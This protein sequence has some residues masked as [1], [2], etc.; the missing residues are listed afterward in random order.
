MP[1]AA[2]DID[3]YLLTRSDFDL[4]LFVCQTLQES[5]YEISHGGT[6][7]DPFKKVPRQFDVRAHRGVRH[8]K[9]FEI[10]LALECKSLSSD[11]PLVVSRV[12]RIPREAF[13]EFVH[14]WPRQNGRGTF[15]RSMRFDGDGGYYRPTDP[16]GKRT[17]QVRRNANGLGFKDD[18]RDTYE[19]WSQALGSANDLVQY[20]AAAGH[21]AA[22]YSFIVPILV[23]S[24]NTLWAVDYGEDG[25]RTGVPHLVESVELFVDRDYAIDI[26][27]YEQ[28]TSYRVGH[29]HILTRAGLCTFLQLL[30]ASE[31]DRERLF[32]RMLRRIGE[33]N[34]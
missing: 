10:Q 18:D 9:D 24:D 15:A 30:D 5:G 21:H 33:A 3:E 27:N 20:A 2:I 13:F 28:H 26:P 32:G 23:V 34:G 22:V 19:K 29:L 14:S 16:V 8:F 6:Y 11:A 1:I 31:R 7:I 17:A 4:E 25:R 12:P